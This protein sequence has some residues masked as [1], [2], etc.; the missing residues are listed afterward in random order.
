MAMATTHALARD[1]YRRR[2][3]DIA[4]TLAR[5]REL[6]DEHARM[7]CHELDNWG[8]VGELGFVHSR[9]DDVSR[10]LRGRT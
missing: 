3:R 9:L 5:I 2:Q 6:V 4:A 10:F 1:A 8:F 7:A